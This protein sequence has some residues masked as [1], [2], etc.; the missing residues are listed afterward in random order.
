MSV[1]RL[2]FDLV[3]AKLDSQR[4]D[5]V[6]LRNQARSSATITGLIGALFAGFIGSERIGTVLFGNGYLGFSIPAA[7]LL[8]FFLFS[9]TMA[10]MVLVNWDDVEFSFDTER[11]VKNQRNYSSEE[12]FFAAY[13]RD[14]EYYWRKN[15]RMISKIQ[16][17]LWWATVL[18]WAQIFPWLIL[19][20]EAH[21]V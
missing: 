5:V 4:S 20:S 18:G 10:C 16:S 15:E 6:N 3:V 7:I 21:D 2:G 14:G 13:V 9:I 1:E 11:L 17:K 12:N 19:I 8:T